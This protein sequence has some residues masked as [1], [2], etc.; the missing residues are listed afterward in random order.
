MKNLVKVLKTLKVSKY[1]IAK[2][3]DVT[4]QSVHN[5]DRGFAQPYK[6]NQIKLIKL[7]LKVKN[8]R[9]CVVD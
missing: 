3:C 8:E 2:H 5:W 9:V 1:A 4:W 7:I 6:S